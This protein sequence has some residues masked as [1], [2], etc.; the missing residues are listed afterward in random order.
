MSITEERNPML[1][2]IKTA[3]IS[4]L[5]TYEFYSR[6]SVSVKIISG[7]HAFQEMMLE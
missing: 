2:G 7:M 4:E 3:I 1:K 5:I 6:S